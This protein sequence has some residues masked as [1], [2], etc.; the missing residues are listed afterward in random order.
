M[1]AGG[2]VISAAKMNENFTAMKTAVDALESK[3]AT[4][5]TKTASLESFRT[6][7]A[8]AKGSVRAFAVVNGIP[9]VSLIAN[10]FTSDGATIIYS[11]SGVGRYR[12]TIPGES[13]FIQSD[14]VVLTAISSFYY[15]I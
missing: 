15:V 9:T 3:V 5:E 10:Q 14:P 12:L 4:L 13:I 7:L 2:D 1:F 11:R 6:G 8:S